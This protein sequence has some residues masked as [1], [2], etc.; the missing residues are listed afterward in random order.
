MAR[1]VVQGTVYFLPR[2]GMAVVRPCASGNKLNSPGG[3]FWVCLS[4]GHI[5]Y[6]LYI[7]M[8]NRVGTGLGL[9]GGCRAALPAD[10]VLLPAQC[11]RDAIPAID[12]ALVCRA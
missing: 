2:T 5:S 9:P 11:E 12:P 6:R 4:G 8:L 7:S 10:A 3:Y 1:E